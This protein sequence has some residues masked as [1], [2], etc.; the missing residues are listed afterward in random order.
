M[1]FSTANTVVAAMA[2]TS[3]GVIAGA[4]AANTKRGLYTSRDAGQTWTYDAWSIP[5]APP[6]LPPPLRSPTT[7]A[8]GLFFAAIRDHGV[9]SS[10]DGVTWTRLNSQPGGSVLGT[11][12]CPPQST[13]NNYACPI[14]RGELTVVPT[15]NDSTAYR[16]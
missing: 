8:R 1:A 11:T 14:Y 2:T 15:R 16:I 9:Y 4:A 3:E 6:T 5:A 7:P 12:A 10:P 13:S